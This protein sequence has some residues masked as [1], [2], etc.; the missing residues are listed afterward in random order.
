MKRKKRRLA[1][2]MV[3]VI[4]TCMLIPYL[5][6][7][8]TLLATYRIWNEEQLGNT[9][10][11][12]LESAGAIAMDNLYAA[13]EA[14]REVSY[15]GVIRKGYETWLADGDENAMYR[16]VTAYLNR[17]F[18]YARTVSHTF[19]LY[20]HPMSREY[21][22]YSN[23]AGGTYAEVEAFK[24]GSAGILR[25]IASGLDTRTAFAQMGDHLYVV[26]N[27][28][29][30][31]YDPFAVLILEVN[32]DR[33]FECMD[34]VIWNQ[35]SITC[36]EGQILRAA[37]S[38]DP[39]QETIMQEKAKTFLA[40]EEACKLHPTEGRSQMYYDQ[41]QA[42]SVLSQK[43]N[44]QIFSY[45]LCLDRSSMVSGQS[46]LLGVC[47]TML[48]TLIPLLT[49]TFH[50]FYRNISRPV[51]ALMRG[52]EKIRKGE[53]GVRLEPFDKNEEMGQL[54]DTFNHM[55][56]S[57]E[58][59]FNRIYVEEIAQ[60]DATLKALQSQ[61]NP[62]FLN[63]TL[64]IINWKARLAGNDE[65]SE[66][67][68]A[69]S[70]MMNASMNRNNEMLIPLSEE[71]SYVDAYLYIIRQR[72]GSRFSFTREADEALLDVKV[73]PLII[74][75]VVEN[76]V[77]HGGNASGVI[78]GGLRIFA[79]GMDI[80]IEVRNN[81]ELTEEDQ[82]KIRSLLDTRNV[83]DLQHL[84]RTSIGI[85]NVN[86]RL[87]LIYGEESGLTIRQEAGQTICLMKIC[88]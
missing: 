82:E 16:E 73:P 23:A 31:N 87:H 62:H 55:S 21:Y 50:F 2:G 78:T 56:G 36:L 53:Y 63:N 69:L 52:S 3:K 70:V 28:V 10:R 15:D 88:R 27:L 19:L 39:D 17:T 83:S 14:S 85:R 60:R 40:S 80:C 64:E 66:M 67:I 8:A 12:S 57:L 35:Y 75:P 29:L 45:V 76:A 54:I 65:V 22:T 74:Q 68:S 41:K 43:V 9:L 1:S 18:K 33:L 77:E 26:R 72:F 13:I 86:L 24:T 84:S 11:E 59:S 4:L 6:L 58:E 51:G 37:P 48:L 32:K 79:A 7:S 47:I 44:G 38:P 61:I 49:A 30:S 71:L 34:K 20:V 5:V 25:Q 46:A 81:G 42:L